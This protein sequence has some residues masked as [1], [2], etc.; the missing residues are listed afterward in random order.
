VLY[1][2]LYD[3]NY[4]YN[5]E[6]WVWLNY[7]QGS[8]GIFVSESNRPEETATLYTDGTGVSAE[9]EATVST[10]ALGSSSAVLILPNP[11]KLTRDSVFRQVNI[12]WQ[13]EGVYYQ[14][15]S[16]GLSEIDLKAVAAS[17]A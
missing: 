3:L 6:Q 4:G 12:F 2:P 17:M 8:A 15:A 9:L 5:G 13:R 1:H 7:G 14:V 10:I 16:S 11:Q